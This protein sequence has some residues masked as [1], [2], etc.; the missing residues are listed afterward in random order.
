MS[1]EPVASAERRGWAA[2]AAGLQRLSVERG[3][4]EVEAE[5][6]ECVSDLFCYGFMSYK[7]M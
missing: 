4:E 5:C 7:K 2:M 3:K 1:V 6:A